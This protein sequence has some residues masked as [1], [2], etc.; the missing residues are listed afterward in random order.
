MR[1]TCESHASAN[2]KQSGNCHFQLTAGN[3]RETAPKL[4]TG[5][6]HG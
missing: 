6:V 2:N 1:I 4:Q 3:L 5:V